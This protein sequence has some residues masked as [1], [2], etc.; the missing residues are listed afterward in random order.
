MMEPRVP[1]IGHH[2][3]LLAQSS[4]YWT[5]CGTVMVMQNF[6]MACRTMPNANLIAMLKRHVTQLMRLGLLPDTSFYW[7]PEQFS[8]H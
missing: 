3:A 2:T 6:C 8:E 4:W 5:L 1:L 7:Q